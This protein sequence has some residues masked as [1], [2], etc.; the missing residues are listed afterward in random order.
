M[1]AISVAYRILTGWTIFP[2]KGHFRKFNSE[3][4]GITLEKGQENAYV[5]RRAAKDLEHTVA[6]EIV[7]ADALVDLV[8][9]C[10][11]VRGEVVQVEDADEFVESVK[12]DLERGNVPIVLFHVGLPLVRN[13]G[14]YR[15]ARGEKYRHW[16]AIVGAARKGT[17]RPAASKHFKLTFSGDYKS[18]DL[19]VWNWGQPFLVGGKE[20]GKASALSIDWTG[21][22]PRMFEKELGKPCKL[23]WLEYG[24][25]DDRYRD[26]VKSPRVRYVSEKPTRD[27]ASLGY[28][29]VSPL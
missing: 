26:Q 8:N 24:P 13:S 14:L 11:D 2:T 21:D 10:E 3:L 25:D 9:L 4:Y 20:L 12:K 6:G 5:L 19:L 28:V 7:N 27:L 16:V 18:G 15:P 22:R 29:R 1:T 17:W 23:A